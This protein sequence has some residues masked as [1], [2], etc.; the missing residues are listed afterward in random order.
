MNNMTIKR[1]EKYVYVVSQ[2]NNPY[3]V[4][5]FTTHQKA[6]DF[7]DAMNEIEMSDDN[8]YWVNYEPVQID[9]EAE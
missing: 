9:R 4:G 1:V 8:K 6:I 2:F 7:R 3:V 5:V